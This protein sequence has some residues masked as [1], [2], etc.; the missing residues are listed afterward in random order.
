MAELTR[1][2]IEG[3]FGLEAEDK[4]IFAQELQRVDHS[5]VAAQDSASL[6]R[7]GDE[8][9]AL[10]HRIIG[11]TAAEPLTRLIS[12]LNDALTRRVI[13]V[14][15]A[16]TQLDGVR[17]CWIALGS[18]G[19]QEQTLASDQD[20]GII[21]DGNGSTDALREMFL[22]L[23]LRIN[24]ALAA[25]GFPLCSGQ[26]MASNPKWCLSLHEWRERFLT[27]IIEGDPQA[28]LNATIFFDLRPLYGAHDL[29]QTL[30]AWLKVN[31]SDNPRFLFQMTENALRR[32]APLGILRD[33]VVEKSGEFAG[34]IDLK[35]NAATLFVD[36]ARVYGLACGSRSS[37]T[38]D[39]LM[40][41]AEAHCVEVSDVEAWI[42]AFYFIEMLRLKNQ[43]SCYA[44]GMALHNHIDPN[45]LD[46]HD[47]RALL[48]ALQQA[49]ALQKRLA[50]AYLGSSQSI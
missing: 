3:F 10:V 1:F 24:Q 23:A 27:W 29:A 30:D 8:I 5:I 33:F 20:N 21:F 17:W 42:R 18:E 25:C 9:R 40:H 39:R 38:A 49:R 7:A 48:H 2:D 44:R 41:A 45:H 12:T 35:L 34:T 37:N 28:L 26:I 32:E 4:R 16:G 50:H 22:P 15:C 36:A 11:R 31:V 43:Q 46:A 6:Q 14:T 13:E 47:R 19:R